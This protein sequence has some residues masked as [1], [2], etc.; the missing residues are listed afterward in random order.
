MM[1]H[2]FSWSAVTKCNT[3]LTQTLFRWQLPSFSL[4]SWTRFALSLER[5]TYSHRTQH[6][7]VSKD[8]KKN[9]HV[10][11]RKTYSVCDLRMYFSK[12]CLSNF[13]LSSWCIRCPHPSCL[14][15]STPSPL[16]FLPPALLFLLGGLFRHQLKK[17]KQLFRKNSLKAAGSQHP[18]LLTVFFSF[19]FPFLLL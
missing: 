12:E 17:K 15:F 4:L 11:W 10:E 9:D 19:F 8:V 2:E 18:S 16:S 13:V 5:F 1:H 3:S 14:V 7:A 6:Q